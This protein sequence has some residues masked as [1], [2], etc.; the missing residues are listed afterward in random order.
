[1]RIRD[2]LV[3]LVAAVGA[4]L[5]PA[6]PVGAQNDYVPPAPTLSAFP[7][8]VTVG[9]DITLIG[10]GFG[11]NDLVIITASTV[12]AAAGPAAPEV[13]AAGPAVAGSAAAGPVAERVVGPVPAGPALADKHPGK[14]RG[15]D[16]HVVRADADGNF[17]T[18]LTML[19]IGRI[20]I[21]A[22]GFPSGVSASVV[23][24][25]LA[26]EVAATG[27]A[28]GWLVRG[29]IAAS[30]TGAALLAT[31]LIWRRRTARTSA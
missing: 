27:S 13:I 19:E 7:T 21:T 6:A 14:G 20:Q 17:T 5:L 11:P 18:R 4:A 10:S 15:P 24:T 3:P 29:G 26:N 30:V 23:V 8:T 25:V 16:K 22:T 1:M 12:A 2:L 31:M 28:S 9:D